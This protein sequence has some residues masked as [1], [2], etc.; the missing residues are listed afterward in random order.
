MMRAIA[1]L[2]SR[3]AWGAPQSWQPL[4]FGVCSFLR[5]ASDPAHRLEGVLD[6]AHV[7][8]ASRSVD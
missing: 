4:R 7:K 3:R 2:L 6:R 5:R 1:Y 8:F